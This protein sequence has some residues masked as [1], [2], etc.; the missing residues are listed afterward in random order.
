MLYPLRILA[1]GDAA[2]RASLPETIDPEVNAWCV[3]LA[4]A[5]RAQLAGI[6]RDVVV[7]YCTVTVYFDAAATDPAVVER[8][9]STCAGRLDT[10]R[11]DVGRVVEVPVCSKSGW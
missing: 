7:G 4:E 8:A 11:R 6:A 5:V 10:S 1:A 2:V 9:I 3:A